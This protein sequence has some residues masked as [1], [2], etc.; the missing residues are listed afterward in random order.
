MLSLAMA[1]LLLVSG[2]ADVCF[3][4]TTVVGS[5]G[6]ADGA[7][8]ATRVCHSGRHMRLEPAAAPGGT[9]FILRLDEGRAFRLDPEHKRAIE[10]DTTRLRAQSH[11]DLAMAGDLMGLATARP[12]TTP[13]QRGLTVAGYACRGF[14]IVAGETIFDLY[15]TSELPLK[16]DA[17][18]DFLEWTG[19]RESMGPILDQIRAL[20]G[21]PLETRSRVTVM[22]E[23]QETR[24]T[25][26]RVTLG[27]VPS[28]LFEVPAGWEIVKE[29]TEVP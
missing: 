14:R 19:A 2:S 23:V 25:V 27:A 3:E 22:G 16:V 26:T 7:G 18:T 6:R 17:F 29:G 10:I 4:Q 20:P 28:K 24:T 1:A 9:A 12:R 5:G 13:L 21:F 11:A 15:V 8:V